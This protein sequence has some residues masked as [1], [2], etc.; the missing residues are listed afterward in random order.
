MRH[1]AVTVGVWLGRGCMAIALLCVAPV[2]AQNCTATVTDIDFGTPPQPA[3]GQVD[4]MAT[5]FL[6]CGGIGA[7]T[8]I[9]V[10]PSLDYGSGGGSA[11]TRT[12]LGPG[13]GTV[14]YGLY[15]DAARLVPW[16]SETSP[17]LGTVPPIVLQP[18]SPGHDTAT[19]M[20][21][22]RLFLPTVAAPG[23]YTSSFTGAEASFHWARLSSGDPGNCVGFVGKGVIHPE[24]DVQVNLAAGCTVTTADLVFPTTGLLSTAVLSQTNLWVTCAASTNY[25][26]SLDYGLHDTSPS[27]RMVS[28]AGA[29][30]RYEL[31]RDAARLQ[32]WG[33]QE[34][35]LAYAGTG[36]G[37]AQNLIVYGRVPPQD[38]P[39]PN[40]YTDRVI[41]TVSY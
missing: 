11:G 36:T 25:A 15:Q 14:T 2:W 30:V 13:G 34:E 39:A 24:F 31:F 8:L 29:S 32:P 23:V 7:G 9:K 6:D 1:P 4:T 35:G 41:V 37:A 40:Q 16:G 17:E 28:G 38:T 33:L 12:L 3:G 10:C 22:A 5:I 27:R 18:A 20:L 21:Y 19:V 26:V